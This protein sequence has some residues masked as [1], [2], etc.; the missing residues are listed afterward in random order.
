[1]S[2]KNKLYVLLPLAGRESQS[3]LKQGRLIWTG[4]L[5]ASR[6]IFIHVEDWQYDYLDRIATPQGRSLTPIFAVTCIVAVSITETSF[7]GP[8]AV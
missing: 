5:S 7:E 1:M 4:F 6:Q 3:A 2:I 8:F